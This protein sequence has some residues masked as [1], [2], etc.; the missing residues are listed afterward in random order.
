MKIVRFVLILMT[1]LFSTVVSAELYAPQPRD[2]FIK[3]SYIVTFKPSKPGV[4]S[5]ILP[6]VIDP[7]AIGKWPT[8]K[9]DQPSS[10]Q[11]KEELAATLGIKGKVLA[12]FEANNAAHLQIDVA[13]AE[14]LRWDPRVLAIEQ[15]RMVVSAQTAPTVQNNPGWGLDRMDQPTTVLNQ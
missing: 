10:G 2:P 7:K 1:F 8:R 11:N 15:D 14:K 12:I 13:Q 9:L 6:P 3:D 5:V 4:S